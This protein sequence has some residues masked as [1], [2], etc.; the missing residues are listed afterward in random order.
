MFIRRS[1]QSTAVLH[2]SHANLQIFLLFFLVTS[3][4]TS[5]I[6]SSSEGSVISIS[7]SLS[8][9]LFLSLSVPCGVL[10]AHHVFYLFLCLNLLYSLRNVSVVNSTASPYS[11]ALLR[12]ARFFPARFL[13]CMSGASE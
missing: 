1:L 6:C 9:S 10:T 3:S 7:L 13:W 11:L 12:F 5:D 4:A 2:T 8:L